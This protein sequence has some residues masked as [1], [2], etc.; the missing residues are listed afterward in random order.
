MAKHEILGGKVHLYKRPNSRFWQCSTYMGGNRRKS[1]KKES[2][3]QAIDHAEDWYVRLKDKHRAGEL[4]GGKTFRA[5]AEQFKRE[6]RII[7]QGK[8]SP[9]YVELLETKLR[10]HLVPY[11]GDTPVNEISPGQL[12]EYRIHRAENGYRGKSPGQ[13]TMAHEMIAFRQVMKTAHRHQWLKVLPDFSDPFRIPGKVAHRAWF[14]QQE[15]RQLYE[16]TRTRAKT[17]KKA[18]WKWESEQLHDYV[19]FMANTGLRPDEA[20]RLQF[21]DVSIVRDYDTGEVILEIEVRGKTGFGHCKSMPRAVI[22][23]RRL[24]KRNNYKPTDL[25]FPGNH[26]ALFNNILQE[27][28]LKFDRDGRRR[29]AYSLRHS[30]ICFRL[31]EGAD[32]YQ[33]AKN[34]RTSVEMIEKHYAVHLKN[35]LDASAINV[36]KRR[37]LRQ[38]HDK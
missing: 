35:T 14:S 18:Y 3:E 21:Q 34:C 33:I 23:F 13:D 24:T 31:M 30:Y 22:P 17:P 25:I 32:I 15:Y 29:T 8:R 4:K 9:K 27:L 1:T 5:A 10:V 16:A 36:R 11:F 28:N 37:T 12:Q 38:P 19:L 26:R 6:F 7:T 2:L 20:R